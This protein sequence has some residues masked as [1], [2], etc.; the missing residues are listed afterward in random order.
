MPTQGAFEESAN[1][2]IGK[3]QLATGSVATGHWQVFAHNY[4]DTRAVNARPDNSGVPAESIDVNVQT[5]G[6]SF[7]STYLNVWGAAQGG[8]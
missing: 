4:R 2:T 7:A 1:P 8:D 6:A 5:V 3:V